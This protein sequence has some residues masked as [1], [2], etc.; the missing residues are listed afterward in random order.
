VHSSS[1]SVVGAQAERVGEV[2][3]IRLAGVF[4]PKT[5][6][7]VIPVVRELLLEQ[8]ARAV[9]L[10]VQM[11]VLAMTDVG[12]NALKDRA[13]ATTLP[14]PFALVVA[15]M[16][17]AEIRAYCR[18][19]ADRGIVRGPFIGEPGAIVWASKCRE[20]WPARPRVEAQCAPPPPPGWQSRRPE[21]IVRTRAL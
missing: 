9:V 19:M 4:T 21:R 11:A 3:V 6:E 15:P 8:D 5:Y 16:Y 1:S 13:T 17:E 18:D 10:N 12:W 7:I 14:H 2:L 20:H